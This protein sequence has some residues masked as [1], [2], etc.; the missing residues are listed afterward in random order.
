MQ[1]SVFSA[2]NLEIAWC[3][4]SEY[5]NF[6]ANFGRNFRNSDLNLDLVSK[7]CNLH[8]AR[9]LNTGISQRIFGRNFRNSELNLEIGSK[10]EPKYSRFSALNLEIGSDEILN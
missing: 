4:R 9:G 1:I 7:Y 5:W 3:A 8:G 10:S 6:R 2:L